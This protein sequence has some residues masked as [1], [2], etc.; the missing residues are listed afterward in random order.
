MTSCGVV[1]VTTNGGAVGLMH[2]FA[3]ECVTLTGLRGLRHLRC[4]YVCAGQTLLLVPRTAPA[5]V[6]D[7]LH[8]ARADTT[9]HTHPRA[10]LLAAATAAAAPDTL[11]FLLCAR[12]YVGHR[13]AAGSEPV[14][15]PLVWELTPAR[16][17]RPLRLRTTTDVQRGLVVSAWEVVEELVR[18]CCPAAAAA[19][20]AVDHAALRALPT[21]REQAVACGALAN[22][23][24]E[25][26]S[27]GAASRAYAPAL[28]HDIAAL[29]EL[30]FTALA[31]DRQ[32]QQQQHLQ[33]PE[34]H[35]QEQGQDVTD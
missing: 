16:T 29:C 32:Q 23:L 31:R 25:V 24:W 22:F 30:H 17:W 4:L 14:R 34:E 9:S 21:A 2:A 18:A 7:E 15:R 20:F 19:P 12:C 35:D 8:A 28:W 10:L 1:I 33:R 11:V 27:V 3:N 13:A 26:W 5:P 6:F